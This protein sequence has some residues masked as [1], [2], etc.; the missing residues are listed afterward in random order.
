MLFVMKMPK[1]T[2]IFNELTEVDRGWLWG[3]DASTV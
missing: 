3:S 2:D 1:T